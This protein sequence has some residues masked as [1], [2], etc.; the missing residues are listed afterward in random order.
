M[1]IIWVCFIVTIALYIRTGETMPGFSWL[2]FKNAKETFETLAVLDFLYFFWAWRRLYC[3]ALEAVQSQPENIRAVTRWMGSWM[4]VLTI[5]E[6][7]TLFGLA[8]Q[9]GGQTL[10]QS[11]PFYVVGSLLTLWLWP[12]QFWPS[13]NA[14][15][16]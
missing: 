13:A 9:L 5:A 14:A 2:R 12:R 11:S 3:P 16:S 10:Q 7:E 6:T 15:P 1:R 8:S 4:I